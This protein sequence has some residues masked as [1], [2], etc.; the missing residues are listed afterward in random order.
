MK[1]RRRS[2][3]EIELDTQK[4]FGQL[5]DKKPTKSAKEYFDRPAYAVDK[6]I[7]AQVGGGSDGQGNDKGK[8]GSIP[9]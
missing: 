2:S 8:V 3:K 9:E 7:R 5:A 1:I 4:C 6:L